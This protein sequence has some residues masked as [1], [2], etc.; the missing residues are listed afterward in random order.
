MPAVRNLV[1]ERRV[2][3]ADLSALQGAE[4]LAECRA[5]QPGL[6]AP[7]MIRIGARAI[8]LEPRWILDMA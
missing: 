8:F 3:R 4:S 7:P 6:I 2:R 5:R 1:L